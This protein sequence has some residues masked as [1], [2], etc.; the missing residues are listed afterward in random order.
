MS[1]RMFLESLAS[2]R[3]RTLLSLS[4]LMALG[5]IYIL[6]GDYLE[7]SAVEQLAGTPPVGGPPVYIY[8]LIGILL[9]ITVWATPT[10]DRLLSKGRKESS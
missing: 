7:T 9:V 2:V 4:V 6:H 8:T 5:S 3:N 1:W 10:I